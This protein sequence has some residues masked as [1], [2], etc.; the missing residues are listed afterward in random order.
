M[1]VSIYSYDVHL[2][3]ALSSVVRTVYNRIISGDVT[4]STG[5]VQALVARRRARL[6][7]QRQL[8]NNWQTTKL[9]FRSVS[10]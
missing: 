2:Q 9:S 4:D 1:P 7:H 3:P 10:S 6:R 8:Y 5:M